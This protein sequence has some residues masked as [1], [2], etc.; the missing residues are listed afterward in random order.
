VAEFRSPIAVSGVELPGV[1]VTDESALPKWRF[2]HDAFEVPMGHARRVDGRLVLS[3]S[4]GEWI[5]VG[6]APE[7]VE[8]VDLTH[9]RAAVRLTGPGAAARLAT[10]CA[11]DFDDRMFPAGAAGRTLVAGVATEIAR[12]DQAGDPSYLLFMSRSFAQS[13]WERLV[14]P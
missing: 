12:D 13:V 6:D 5:A 11:L 3:V 9:V 8:L 7:G 4:P 2:W 10:V 14:V 1:V